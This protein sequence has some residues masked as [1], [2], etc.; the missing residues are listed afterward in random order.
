MAERRLPRRFEVIRWPIPGAWLNLN[1]KNT[2]SFDSSSHS[3]A[4]RGLSDDRRQLGLMVDG[5]KLETLAP[6]SGTHPFFLNVGS[7]QDT[8]DA[9]LSGFYSRDR[10]SY[11]WTEAQAQVK[12]TAPLNATRPLRLVVR[13]VKS[14]PDASFR[15]WI[16]VS[17]DGRAAG[18]TELLGTGMEFREYSFMLQPGTKSRRPVIEIAVQPPWNP[19]KAGGSA[20]SRTLGCAID[21][22]RIE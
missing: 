10:D 20:D 13:A 4:E 18:R 15:Q 7:E 17:V 5:V 1:G 12:L 8:L 21:W 14:C 3:P 6:V 2:I 19:A 11:R 22:M 9:D 16:S